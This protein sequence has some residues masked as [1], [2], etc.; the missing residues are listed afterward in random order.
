MIKGWGAAASIMFAVVAAV[1]VSGCGG[2]AEADAEKPTASATA[3]PVSLGEAKTT[4]QDA[5]TQF[6]TDGGCLEREPGT[7]WEQM[8]ALMEPARTV[9]KAMNA[10]KSVGADFWTEAYALIDT[11]EK[12]IA[13]GEDQGA[14]V[15]AANDP[16]MSNRDDV[17]GSAH[18]LA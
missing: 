5:V 1:G 12:G 17:L 8:Q 4:L 14:P 10:E 7:C 15:G 3:A 16:S 18:D 6:D 11:M 9:R 2:D 13:V